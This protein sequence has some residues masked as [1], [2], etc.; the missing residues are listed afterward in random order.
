MANA[1]TPYGFRPINKDGS[2][3]SGSLQKVYYAGDTSTTLYPGDPV[4]LSGTADSNGVPAVVRAD[5]AGPV[6]GVVSEVAGDS[7]GDLL[8]DTTRYLSTTAGYANIVRAQPG[9]YFV[10]Q[11]DS[12]GQNLAAVDVGQFAAFVFGTPSTSHPIISAA[13][14][15]SSSVDSTTAGAMRII[16]LKQSVDNAIGTNAEWIVEFVDPTPAEV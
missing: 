10:A 13:E 7:N 3:W 16:G 14:I 1:D 6:W 8:R 15:D 4:K 9:Q 12:V 11:E 2:P 5:A